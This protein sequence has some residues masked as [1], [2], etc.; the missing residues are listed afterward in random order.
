MGEPRGAEVGKSEMGEL[1]VRE[2]SM[3]PWG[4]LTGEETLSSRYAVWSFPVAFTHARPPVAFHL[5]PNSGGCKFD[6]GSRT[7]HSMAYPE[8]VALGRMHK[9]RI[10]PF[11]LM[12]AVE[13]HPVRVIKSFADIP[14]KSMSVASATPVP[15]SRVESTCPG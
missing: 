1:T 15:A 11:S 9:V 2:H 6:W 10:A 8:Q 14:S 3:T 4:Y 7:S 12:H 5:H 13:A